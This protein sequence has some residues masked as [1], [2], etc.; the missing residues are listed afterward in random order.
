MSRE[1]S[2]HLEKEIIWEQPPDSGIYD[3]CGY[4]PV[5]NADVLIHIP[6]KGLQLEALFQAESFLRQAGVS[7]D[8]GYG[9]GGRDWNFDW[10]LKGAYV[11]LRKTLTDQEQVENYFRRNLFC[12][13]S[14]LDE[15]TPNPE[16]L[17]CTILSDKHDRIYIVVHGTR[18]KFHTTVIRKLQKLGCEA[19]DMNPTPSDEDDSKVIEPKFSNCIFKQGER[20]VHVTYDD[21]ERYQKM[22]VCVRS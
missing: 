20:T 19:M 12:G 1:E 7:F 10:S 11:K 9:C 14:M 22:V 17:S 5:H 3:P 16:Y 21:D 8:T 13:Y 6:A 4:I 18:D 15:D 2:K